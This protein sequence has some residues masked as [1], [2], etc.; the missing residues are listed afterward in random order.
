MQKNLGGEHGKP[1][2]YSCLDRPYGQ[3]SLVNYGPW[4]HRV[5]DMTGVTERAAC[6]QKNEDPVYSG[7]LVKMMQGGKRREAS[8]KCRK[9]EKTADSKKISSPK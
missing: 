2:R 7:V 8:L 4:G 5:S 3:S 6:I 1:L 9:E